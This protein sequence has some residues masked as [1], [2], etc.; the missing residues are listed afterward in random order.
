MITCECDD[1]EEEQEKELFNWRNSSRP[2]WSA[3]E[4]RSSAETSSASL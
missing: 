4:A 1:G 3:E 2:F